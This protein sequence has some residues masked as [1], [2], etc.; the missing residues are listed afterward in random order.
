MLLM[1]KMT[2]FWQ[3]D[4]ACP[5]EIFPDKVCGHNYRIAPFD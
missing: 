1:R 3:S 2:K 5:D 4:K